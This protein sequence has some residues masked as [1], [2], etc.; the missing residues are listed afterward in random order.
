VQARLDDPQGG[1]QHLCRF[2]RTQSFD[3]A[4]H[5][6]DSVS[7]RE[8]IDAAP[9]HFP[10]LLL[11]KDCYRRSLPGRRRIDLVLAFTKVGKQVFD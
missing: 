10:R 6:D 4:Q 9:N 7:F 8:P 1:F 5:Q 2:F 3:V 11:L